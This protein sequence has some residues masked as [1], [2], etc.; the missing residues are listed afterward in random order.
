MIIIGGRSQGGPLSDVW[1]FSITT[2][3]WSQ[4]VERPFG[5]RM[6]ARCCLL[7]NALVVFGAEG[8]GHEPI[9]AIDSK[10]PADESCGSWKSAVDPRQAKHR[11]D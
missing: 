5:E 2:K 6:G 7:D 1:L 3:T 9:E 11:G 4:I 10:V 8:R